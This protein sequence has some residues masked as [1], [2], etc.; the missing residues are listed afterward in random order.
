LDLKGLG[1]D[2][3]WGFECRGLHG[4]GGELGVWFLGKFNIGVLFL[5][6][7]SFKPLLTVPFLPVPF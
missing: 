1:L 7:F 4:V 3:G 2:W 5:P 6:I